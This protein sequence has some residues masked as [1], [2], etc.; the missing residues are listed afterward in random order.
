MDEPAEQKPARVPPGSR[1]VILI[2]GPLVAAFG[3]WVMATGEIGRNPTPIKGP[4]AVA[5]GAVFTVFAG[6]LIV[7][8]W[9]ERRRG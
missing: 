3:I 1:G 4:L 8:A 9:S 6:I 5:I 2:L 7:I